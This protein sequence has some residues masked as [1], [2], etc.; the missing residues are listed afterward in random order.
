[1]NVD[2]TLNEMPMWRLPTVVS[3]EVAVVLPTPTDRCLDMRK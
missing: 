3:R 1:M 2:R